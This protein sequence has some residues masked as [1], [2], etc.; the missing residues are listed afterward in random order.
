VPAHRRFWHLA[1]IEN[2]FQRFDASSIAPLLFSKYSCKQSI[3][4]LIVEL[5]N[6]VGQIGRQDMS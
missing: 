1:D 5:F 3:E 2:E 6:R 4:F